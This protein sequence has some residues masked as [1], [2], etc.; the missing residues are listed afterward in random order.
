MPRGKYDVIIF[1]ATSFVGGILTRYIAEQYGWNKDLKWA[2]AGRSER[3]LQQVRGTLAPILGDQAGDV[4]YII[5]DA[6]DE[7]SLTELCESTRVI[8][9]TVG[10]YALYG[11]P[12]VK[13]CVET[14]IDYCDLTGEPQ[15]IKRMLDKYESKAA[16]TGARIVHCCGF[17]SIPSDMGVRHLQ[18]LAKE[19]VGHTLSKV[20]M[21]VKAAKGGMSGGTI[22]SMLQLTKE[23]MTNPSLKKELANPYS[24]C[25][26]DHGF[27]AKQPDIKGAFFDRA[28]NAWGMPF[29]M[30]AINTRVVH[31][32]N[33]LLEKEYGERFLYNEGMLTGKG[34]K[35]RRMAKAMTLGLGAFI[36]G[37]AIK[38][39]RALLEKFVLPKPGQGPSPK[40]QETGYFDIRFYGY[41]KEYKHGKEPVIATKV[42]GDK[43]PGYGFTGKMLGEA[44]V[45]LALDYHNRGKK[46]WGKGGFW[47]PGSLFGE[48]FMERLQKNANM[49]F[50]DITPADST[51]KE[52]AEQAA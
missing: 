13:A 52:S 11:E 18:E 22:A 24:L 34:A 26:P 10:P 33:A 36:V 2:M 17:D 15:W 31:R 47:T 23:V 35:G 45:C 38:P 46:R 27:R 43:D 44:A 49:T 1:G 16:E 48:V 12:L 19:K 39:T 7:A 9:S 51:D 50:E 37:A 32:T 42:T 5:A 20:E 14:G 41:D 25:P 3:K 28:S 40:E 6:A 4:E 29:I 30:A 8:V 21:R